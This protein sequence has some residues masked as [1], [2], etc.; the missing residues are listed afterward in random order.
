MTDGATLDA[1]GKQL[2]LPL[3]EATEGNAGYDI[4][5]LLKETGNVTLDGVSIAD[6]VAGLSPLDC[7]PGA[8]AILAPGGTLTCTASY[9]VTS[10]D[11]ENGGVSNT[12][13]ATGTDPGGR[14]VTDDDLPDFQLPGLGMA[15]IAVPTRLIEKQDEEK[16]LAIVRK[17]RAPCLIVPRTPTTFPVRL[18]KLADGTPDV[19]ERSHFV[20]ADREKMKTA[21]HLAH[22]ADFNL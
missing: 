5:A 8:P 15:A 4:S 13:T 7:A 21:L 9:R 22:V 16:S 10:A 19:V 17:H 11:L 1:A 14:T 2:D 3:V 20:F 12:A 18:V 6:P